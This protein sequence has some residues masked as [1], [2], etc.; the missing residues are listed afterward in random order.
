MQNSICE[1]HV[2]KHLLLLNYVNMNVDFGKISPNQATLGTLTIFQIF[3]GLF[4]E[5]L[6]L[7]F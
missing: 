5:I 4:S 2:L 6:N 7:L 3:E 1:V